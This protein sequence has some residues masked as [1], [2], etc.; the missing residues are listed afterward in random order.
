MK[1][2]LVSLVIPVYNNEGSLEELN[3][4]I[5]HDLISVLPGYDFEIIYVNDNS[6]DNSLVI[7]KKITK[8]NK[9][10]IVVNLSR[11]FGQQYAILAGWKVSK[12][13]VAIDLAADLQDPPEQCI[14]MLGEWEHGNKVVV[15]YRK[16][17]HVNISRKI[18]SRLFYRLILPH[19]PKGGFDFT[20]LDRQPLNEIIGFRDKNRFYQA[21]I[22]SLGFPFKAIPYSKLKRYS[23]K[24]QFPTFKRFNLFLSAYLNVSYTPLR[25]FSILG[26]I[27]TLIGFLYGLTVLLAYFTGSL[28][29]KGWAPIMLTMLLLGGLILSSLGIIGE[30]IWRILDEVRGRPNYIIENIIRQDDDTSEAEK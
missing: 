23:G 5:H 13:D 3:K 9:N 18:T 2:K 10:V 6:V 15:S 12:G 27:V 25:F 24:S 20:L 26:I 17:V 19:A 1:K 21:D 11:N 16:E 22:L 4:R 7:L 30:Y 29:T 14:A 8:Y 28:P